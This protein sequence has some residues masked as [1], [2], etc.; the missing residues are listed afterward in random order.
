METE[1]F[2]IIEALKEAFREDAIEEGIEKGLEKG[3]VI[4]IEKGKKI[5][6]YE[7]SLRG[8]SLEL[9]SNVFGLSIDT[10][11]Q[12]IEEMKNDKEVS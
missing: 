7:A 12:I 11:K 9:L 8:H 4:G 1:E 6:I 2:D 10:I 3:L 5:S